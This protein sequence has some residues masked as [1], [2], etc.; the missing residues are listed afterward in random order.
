MPDHGNGWQGRKEDCERF[1]RFPKP[2]SGT[3]PNAPKRK[4]L[5]VIRIPYTINAV[6]VRKTT[7]KERSGLSQPISKTWEFDD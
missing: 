7:Q 6:P 5:A 4:P 3:L 1:Q 2:V